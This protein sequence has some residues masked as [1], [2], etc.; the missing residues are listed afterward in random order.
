MSPNQLAKSLVNVLG[1]LGDAISALKAAE[2]E[3]RASAKEILAV[4]A[5]LAEIRNVSL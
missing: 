2:K 3:Q 1:D 5:K 4:R